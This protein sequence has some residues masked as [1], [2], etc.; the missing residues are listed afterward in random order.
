M[1]DTISVPY[2]FFYNSADIFQH[3]VAIVSLSYIVVWN[4]SSYINFYKHS[5]EQNKKGSL[6]PNYTVGAPGMGLAMANPLNWEY[7]KDPPLLQ[8]AGETPPAVSIK[9][10]IRSFPG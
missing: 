5:L 3:F 9:L 2:K 7:L 6:R 10:S 1:S 8:L 4:I